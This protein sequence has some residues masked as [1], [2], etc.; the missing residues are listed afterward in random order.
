MQTFEL[1]CHLTKHIFFYHHR[2]SFQRTQS[3]YAHVKK[4]Q[5]E[6]VITAILNVQQTVSNY[7]ERLKDNDYL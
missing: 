5:S 4:Y 3:S 1:K 7:Q 2:P 6:N